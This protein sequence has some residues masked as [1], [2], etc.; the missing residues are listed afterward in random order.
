MERKKEI[1]KYLLRLNTWL[2]LAVVL[3]LGFNIFQVV[4][5]NNVAKS[6]EKEQE[7]LKSQISE[8]NQTI[9][10]QKA[11]ENKTLTVQATSTEVVKYKIPE[12]KFEGIMK[13]LK[14]NEKAMM[15][16]FEFSKDGEYLIAHLNV[17][18]GS[19]EY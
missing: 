2:I 19:S 14:L 7:N 13:Q 6:N 5:Q 4:N 16:E 3:S 12:I 11:E 10:K 9:E 15:A 18:G 8:L 17:G 1:A